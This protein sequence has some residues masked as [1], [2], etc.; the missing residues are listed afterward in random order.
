MYHLPFL[1]LR[2][3]TVGAGVAFGE[4]AVKLDALAGDVGRGALHLPGDEQDCTGVA[5]HGGSVAQ[6]A[7]AVTTLDKNARSTERTA[8][9]ASAIDSLRSLAR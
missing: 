8:K 1:V 2:G 7:T 5:G 4:G 6:I 9:P 3:V